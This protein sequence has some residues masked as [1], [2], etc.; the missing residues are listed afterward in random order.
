MI[1]L[2]DYKEYKDD[3]EIIDIIVDYNNIEFLLKENNQFKLAEKLQEL[4]RKYTV[5]Q[6]VYNAINTI[7]PQNIYQNAENCMKFLDTL[8]KGKILKKRNKNL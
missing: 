2:D 3:K 5:E 7:P 4:S 6:I 1:N 8:L